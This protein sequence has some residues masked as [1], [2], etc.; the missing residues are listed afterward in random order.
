MDNACASEVIS[1]IRIV[2]MVKIVIF[3]KLVIILVKPAKSIYKNKLLFFSP[4]TCTWCDTDIKKR[5][6]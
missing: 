6:M 4:Y 2:L 3:V 1:I 5:K